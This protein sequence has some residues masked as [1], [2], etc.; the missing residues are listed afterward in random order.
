LL[1][2]SDLDR[3][4]G[5]VPFGKRDAYHGKRGAYQFCR[6][7][8]RIPIEN[9]VWKAVSVFGRGSGHCLM[10]SGGKRLIS[11]VHTCFTAKYIENIVWEAVSVFGKEWGYCLMVSIGKRLISVALSVIELSTLKMGHGQM[12]RVLC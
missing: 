7:I 11:I 6:E 9:T 1:A 4:V 10:I 3:G 5:A 2:I 8:Y 12:V